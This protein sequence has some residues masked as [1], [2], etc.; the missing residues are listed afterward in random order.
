MNPEHHSDINTRGEIVVVAHLMLCTSL[1]M[2]G[3]QRVDDRWIPG[4]NE[5]VAGIT[6]CFSKE[7]LTRGYAVYL[8]MLVPESARRPGR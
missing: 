3:E 6:L 4:G 2:N 7:P 5:E 8:L 1:C